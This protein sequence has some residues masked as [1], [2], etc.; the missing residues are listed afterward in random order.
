MSASEEL[1]KSRAHAS[2]SFGSPLKIRKFNRTH[3]RMA[4]AHAEICVH[5]NR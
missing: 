3:R 2:R 4:H 5:F 1:D